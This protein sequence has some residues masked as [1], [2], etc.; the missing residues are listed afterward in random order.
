ML[1]ITRP[2]A[3]HDK[4]ISHALK[5]QAKKHLNSPQNFFVLSIM[6]HLCG[7]CEWMREKFFK[8]ISNE[9]EII[10]CAQSH[11]ICSFESAGY[12]EQ[13]GLRADARLEGK[14]LHP[15]K[16]WPISRLRLQQQVM[17]Y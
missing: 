16:I 5:L 15:L 11:R 9:T 2:I 4:V 17:K 14:R 10:D 12:L 3:S 1:T 7:G 6:R 13:F 8:S